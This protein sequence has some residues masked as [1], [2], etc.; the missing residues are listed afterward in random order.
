MS[1]A[2]NSA[3]ADGSKMEIISSKQQSGM[4]LAELRDALS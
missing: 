4:L 2:H 1:F 3:D